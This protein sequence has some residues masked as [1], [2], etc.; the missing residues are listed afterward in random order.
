MARRSDAAS[1][2]PMR[3]VVHL[4][5]TEAT[6]LKLLVKTG[7]YGRTPAQAVLRLLDEAIEVRLRGRRDGPAENDE[8]GERP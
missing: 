6:L 2:G 8:V 3:L 5:V 1:Q 7:L 4:N